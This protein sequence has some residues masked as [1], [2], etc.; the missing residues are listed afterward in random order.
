M[1]G[2]VMRY[3]PPIDDCGL[4]R[5]LL[6]EYGPTSHLPQF[7][8][9][10]EVIER[11]NNDTVPVPTPNY[12]I[13]YYKDNHLDYWLSGVKDVDML[14]KF[15][16]GPPTGPILDFGGSTG[17]VI[18]HWRTETLA[19]LYLCDINGRFINWAQRYL[20]PAVTAFKNDI[21]PRMP[22]PDNTFSLV[23]AL[24]VFTHIDEFETG[25]LL[26]LKRILKPGGRLLATIH[27]DHTWEMIPN[28]K[29]RLSTEVLPNSPGY[30]EYRKTTDDRPD[31]AVFVHPAS[32]LTNLFFS[33]NYIR[34]H[35]GSILTV[36]GIQD[37]AHNYQAMVAMTKA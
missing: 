14:N 10:P 35:W 29:F 11:L 23:Y 33:N 9:S 22:F 2:S 4:P 34:E 5:D 8:R 27:N 17:R 32:K 12:R 25:W 1:N 16:S 36:D 6:D 30:V 19:P 28:L 31:R 21:A 26:E 18:R 20:S 37:E 3:H 7:L 24:S 13:H 15:L